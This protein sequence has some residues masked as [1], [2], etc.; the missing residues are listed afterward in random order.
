MCLLTLRD[1]NCV[2]TYILFIW[3]QFR[4]ES[5]TNQTAGY[6]N[7]IH[8]EAT[9][10]NIYA[11]QTTVQQQWHNVKMLLHLL[12]IVYVLELQTW[13]H[14]FHQLLKPSF[15]CYH[16]LNYNIQTF[17]LSVPASF[18]ALLLGRKTPACFEHCHQKLVSK[19][20]L[21]SLVRESSEYMKD[22][23]VTFCKWQKKICSASSSSLGHTIC[24]QYSTLINHITVTPCAGFNVGVDRDQ[25]GKKIMPP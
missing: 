12:K 4:I 13:V 8:F 19:L 15:S 23:I 22:G 6:N 14:Y 2:Y 18:L 7:L 20:G 1:T 11:Y 24:I 9:W 16:V 5:F 17:T 25:N 3:L 21:Q 10:R